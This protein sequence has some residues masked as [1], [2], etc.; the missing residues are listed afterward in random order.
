VSPLRPYLLHPRHARPSYQ[1]MNAGHQN[2]MVFVD[3]GTIKYILTV[4]HECREII[5]RH[6]TVDKY[7]DIL[8]QMIRM[9]PFI[10]GLSYIDIINLSRSCKAF[11]LMVRDFW[12]PDFFKHLRFII[13]EPMRS[14]APIAS[15][16]TSMYVDSLIYN[17]KNTQPLAN[18][19]RT[20]SRRSKWKRRIYHRFHER[21]VLNA[22]Y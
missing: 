9:G 13:D 1:K 11:Y 6:F 10:R 8:C 5:N 2:K 18:I 22:P 3:L 4:N 15:G 17:T 14:R 19:T 7:K 16:L 21:A 12:G 20:T